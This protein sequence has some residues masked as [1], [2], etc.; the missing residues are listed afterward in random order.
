M[1]NAG[2]QWLPPT[3]NSRE[4]KKNLYKTT[5]SKSVLIIGSTYSAF[6]HLN[7]NSNTILFFSFFFLLMFADKNIKQQK[8]YIQL[9]K[10]STSQTDRRTDKQTYQHWNMQVYLI[11]F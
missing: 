8:N 9:N 11:L 1:K 10:H 3:L 6:K 5:K 7:K 4:Y 2:V